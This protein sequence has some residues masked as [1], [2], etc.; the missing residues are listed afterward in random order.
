MD[1]DG[2]IP[3]KL[4]DHL[5]AIVVR[6][7][8]DVVVASFFEKLPQQSQIFLGFMPGEEICLCRNPAASEELG[9]GMNI[10]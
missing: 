8:Q 2:Y 1:G 10:K 3:L 7:W 9:Y 5:Y 4:G 6:W